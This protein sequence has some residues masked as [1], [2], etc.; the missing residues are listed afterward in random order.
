[1]VVGA[2]QVGLWSANIAIH[3]RSKQQCCKP[4]YHRGRERI[5]TQSSHLNQNFHSINVQVVASDMRLF[6]PS[7]KADVLVSGTWI[8]W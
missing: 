2:G 6:Q 3:C 4:E 1:M 8:I 7:K 5:Q